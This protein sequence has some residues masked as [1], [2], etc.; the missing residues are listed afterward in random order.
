MPRQLQLDRNCPMRKTSILLG[1]KPRHSRVYVKDADKALPHFKSTP[2][3]APHGGLER[4][5]P[6]VP[7]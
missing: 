3:W 4:L 1:R 2:L 5:C 7:H 6:A